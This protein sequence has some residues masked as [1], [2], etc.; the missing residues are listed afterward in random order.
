MA[1]NLNQFADGRYR[2]AAWGRVPV[3]H[4]T[5]QRSDELMDIE[6]AKALAGL[7][8]RAEQF[9]SGFIVTDDD[10]NE[11]VHA[12]R[13][14]QIVR[15]DTLQ[16]LGSAS[17]RYEIIQNEQMLELLR[18][19]IDS[20][21]IAG[22]I[23]AGVLGNGEK[24]WVQGIIGEFSVDQH[25]R[26]LNTLLLTNSFDTTAAFQGGFSSVYVVCG[27][28]YALARR[29]F[30]ADVDDQ[31]SFSINHKGNTKSQLGQISAALDVAD[32]A[33]RSHEQVA[34]DLA[35]VKVSRA[36]VWRLAV[37]AMPPSRATLDKWKATGQPTGYWINQWN[38]V[39][40]ESRNGPGHD[41]PTRQGTA[42]GA[43]NA[44]TG[45]VD[46]ARQPSSTDSARTNQAL[47]GTGA[48]I[49]TR[50]FEVAVDKFAGGGEWSDTVHEVE[51]ICSAAVN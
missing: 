42:F 21:D 22:I 17:E 35:K 11:T 25:D 3:W 4:G 36:D 51:S 50:A 49:K 48:D 1:A 14:V 6:S 34:R 30:D 38:G 9:P 18:P 32:R 44:V 7:D 28:T 31:V 41:L 39:L 5:G 23:T 27:N 40:D 24:S 37:A 16:P 45:Y 15:T 47:F 33:I 13:G 29:G 43:W 12:G 46:Y 19:F 26:G 10:G 20:G 8:F 2:M